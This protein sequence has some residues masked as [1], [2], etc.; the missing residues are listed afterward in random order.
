MPIKLIL[1]WEV[2]EVILSKMCA[3][4]CSINRALRMLSRESRKRK[5]GRGEERIHR[6]IFVLLLFQI[7]MKASLLP[8][9]VLQSH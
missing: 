9:D 4:S 8:E 6:V 1:T 2:N 3:W 5:R 7:I